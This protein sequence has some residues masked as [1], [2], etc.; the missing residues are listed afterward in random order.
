[1][2]MGV[3]SILELIISLLG[4]VASAFNK[5]GL[6]ELAS[7]VQSAITQ[8]EN[9]QATAVTKPEL[10]GFRVTPQW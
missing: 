6:T 7:G 8:L 3:L 5:T 10:E 4:G 2:D 1:M 9:V